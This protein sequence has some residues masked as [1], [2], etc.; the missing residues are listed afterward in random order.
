[1]PKH[2]DTRWK[3]HP[4]ILLFPFQACRCLETSESSIKK[5]KFF[6]FQMQRASEKSILRGVNI[7]IYQCREE[8]RSCQLKMLRQKWQNEAT[9]SYH[10]SFP[11]ELISARGLTDGWWNGPSP[12]WSWNQ[13]RTWA[14]P[15][16]LAYS[17]FSLIPQLFIECHR[18][19]HYSDDHEWQVPT[20]DLMPPQSL[21]V[22]RAWTGCP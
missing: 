11:C 7:N 5:K 18:P 19:W 9:L 20:H 22:E 13:L 3:L 8:S 1:M 17:F 16:S 4:V 10:D 15:Q 2:P 12:T 14:P 21:L 6:V